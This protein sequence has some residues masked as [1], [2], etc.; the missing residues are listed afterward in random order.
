MV[1]LCTGYYKN[2]ND[3]NDDD[4]KFNIIKK[5]YNIGRYKI[6]YYM[7]EFE[8][9]GSGSYK[10][11][12]PFCKDFDNKVNIYE[13]DILIITNSHQPC[14][15]IIMG[16]DGLTRE[17]TY[18]L[19]P[20]TESIYDMNEKFIRKV[21]D[22]GDRWYATF[23]MNDTYY[24]TMGYDM[25][26][27]YIFLGVC[28][29]KILFETKADTQLIRPYDNARITGLT[30]DNFEDY[31]PIEATEEGII[32]ER[33]SINKKDF[34]TGD[35]QEICNMIWEQDFNE[36]TFYGHMEYQGNYEN[37]KSICYKITREEVKLVKYED[38]EDFDTD[39][40]SD[41]NSS[42]SSKVCKYLEDVMKIADIEITDDNKRKLNTVIGNNLINTSGGVNL[43]IDMMKKICSNTS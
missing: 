35:S 5:S 23:R 3:D 41:T 21:H 15:E 1:K 28:N 16:G 10:G 30:T 6:E 31:N 14:H 2:R 9:Y 36:K 20:D 38:I 7:Y 4:N 22:A 11:S 17:T 18:Y 42:Q 8:Y 27:H 33:Y 40:I 26:T 24:I 43:T 29:S 13:D 32:F 37:K 12:F 39:Y 19:L 25:C 34:I